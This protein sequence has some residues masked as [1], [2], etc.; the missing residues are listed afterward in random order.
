MA[1][2]GGGAICVVLMTAPDRETGE[3]LATALVEERLAACANVVPGILS[4][5]WWKGELERDDEALLVVK[6]AAERVPA[7]RERAVE[8]HPYEV[9]EFVILPVQGGHEP[10]I[11]W[12]ARE[13]LAG[14]RG[15]D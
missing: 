1:A 10:Y 11:Q 2:D 15:E 8:L 13:S 12:V 14:Q 4:L 9:P 7:L 3:A 6:T 5:Y